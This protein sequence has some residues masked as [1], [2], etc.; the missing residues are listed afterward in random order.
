MGGH[1]LPCPRHR[2]RGDRQYHPAREGIEFG[3]RSYVPGSENRVVVMMNGQV[4]AIIVDL[5]NKNISMEKAGDRFHV[6]P[7]H[8]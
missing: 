3:K 4:N 8:R 7:G 5:P 6:L 2:H 1:H